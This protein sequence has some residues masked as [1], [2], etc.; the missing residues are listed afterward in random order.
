MADLNHLIASLLDRS[1][2]N[3]LIY[4]FKTA[5]LQ[6]E[7]EENVAWTLD[8][9]FGGE[10]REVLI[11]DYKQAMRIMVPAGKCFGDVS[12]RIK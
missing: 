1:M 8:G 10:H 3:E 9:E 4:W 11:E 6:V 7:S 2:E 12:G 5:R